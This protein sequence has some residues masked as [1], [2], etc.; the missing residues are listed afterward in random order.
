[1]SPPKAPRIGAPNGMAATTKTM[2]IAHAAR[3]APAVVDVEA[4]LVL[5][6]A[7]LA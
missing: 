1:M 5:L 4:S 7:C 2:A 3:C 6:S